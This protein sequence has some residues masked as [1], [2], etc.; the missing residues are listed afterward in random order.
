MPGREIFLGNIEPLELQKRWF[1]IMKN[2][3]HN[4]PYLGW[5]ISPTRRWVEW[6]KD[7]CQDQNTKGDVLRRFSRGFAI[8]ESVIFF[9]LILLPADIPKWMLLY[10]TWLLLWYA[11]SRIYEVIFAFYQD[12]IRVL[13]DKPRTTDLS[14]TERIIMVA[15]SYFGLI[16]SYAVL[17]YFIPCNMFELTEQVPNLADPISGLDALYFSSVTITTVGYG[18]ILP[19]SPWAKLLVMSE[20]LAGLFLLV[21]SVAIYLGRQQD[22]KL[23]FENRTR[24]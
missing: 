9:L 12:A 7:R 14:A 3:I 24:D 15:K 20:V 23:D 19:V 18:D 5:I 22:T 13:E 21:I 8:I 11:F 2:H 16:V 1:Q 10:G 17:F 6:R 4:I